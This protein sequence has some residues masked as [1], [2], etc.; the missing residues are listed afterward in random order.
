LIT[1]PAQ[2]LLQEIRTGAADLG[3]ITLPVA[4]PELVTVPAME[5]EMLLVA[6]PSH[7]LA[8]KKRIVSQDLVQQPF[9]VFEHASNSRRVIDEFFVKERIQPRI[10]M[11]TENVEILKALVRSEMGITIIPYQAV[12]REVRSGHL[13]CAR[14]SGTHL[15]RQTGWVYQRANKVPRMLEE[16]FKAFER[17]VPKLNLSPGDRLPSLRNKDMS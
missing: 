6:H 11:E 8:K 1:G 4:E 5:E 2:R 15:V 9:V 12:A 16:M 3:F 14:I 7:P 13:A 10:V 17:V